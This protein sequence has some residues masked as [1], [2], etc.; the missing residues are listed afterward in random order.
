MNYIR[1]GELAF[2][3]ETAVA[4]ILIVD[5]DS[6]LRRMPRLL[7]EADGHQ[8]HDDADG[9]AALRLGRQV[10]LDLFICD[11]FMP[12]QDGLETI[13]QFRRAFPAV[14]IVAMSGGGWGSLM[15]LL[16]VARHLG[17]DR[18]LRKPF[19]RGDLLAL[20]DDL[21]ARQPA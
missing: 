11:V 14:P 15:D 4:R 13:Q 8:V 20:L 10:A 1:E 3:T 21:Q 18:I 12:D 5:D 16:P 7:L 17:A 6:P 2:G 19:G 9:A